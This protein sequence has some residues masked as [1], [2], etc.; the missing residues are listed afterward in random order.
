MTT[1][2]DSNNWSEQW[3][4]APGCLGYLGDD[5]LPNYMGII[6]NHYKDPY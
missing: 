1:K 4:K 2:T 6:A 5:I 3:K